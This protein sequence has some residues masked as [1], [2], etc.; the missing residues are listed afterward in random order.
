MTPLGGAKSSA[1]ESRLCAALLKKFSGGS[2]AAA[3]YARQRGAG[4][5]A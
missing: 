5:G 4:K 2:A 3:R 1:R